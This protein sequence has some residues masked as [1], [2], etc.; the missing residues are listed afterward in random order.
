VCV[1]VWRERERERDCEHAYATVDIWTS[2]C[3][4]VRA[5]ALRE[6]AEIILQLSEASSAT[7]GLNSGPQKNIHSK[8]HFPLPDHLAR[9]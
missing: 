1:C 9:P 4:C 5:R 8:K 7:V 3:V 2:L 6:H